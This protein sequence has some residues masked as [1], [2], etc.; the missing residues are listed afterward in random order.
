MTAHAR[1][2]TSAGRGRTA[3]SARVRPPG[4]ADSFRGRAAPSGG[5]ARQAQEPSPPPGAEGRA[6]RVSAGPASASASALSAEGPSQPKKRGGAEAGRTGGAC[7][8]RKTRRYFSESHD[9]EAAC[10]ETCSPNIGTTVSTSTCRALDKRR[11]LILVTPSFTPLLACAFL[12][13]SLPPSPPCAFPVSLQL[14]VP[15]PGPLTLTISL[16]HTSCPHRGRLP[17]LRTHVMTSS[18]ARQAPESPTSPLARLGLGLSPGEAESERLETCLR[19][20]WEHAPRI[21][22]RASRPPPPA[23]IPRGPSAGRAIASSVKQDAM[24]KPA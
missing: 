11:A 14:T 9:A 20:P 13:P 2:E 8:A 22:R 17:V 10:V 24:R 4:P 1:G 7:R 3:P 16:P 21:T 12:P 19:P 18:S 6:P 15:Q 23:P 5:M